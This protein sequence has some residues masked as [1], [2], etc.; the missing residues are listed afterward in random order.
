MKTIGTRIGT[1]DVVTVAAMMVLFFGITLVIGSV[2]LAIPF[3][4]L[5]MSAGIDGFLGAAF[6]LVAANR[7]NKHGL[8]LIW[9][10]VYG[11][12]LYT[13]DAADD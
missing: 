11:C 2:A 1:R 5:Y 6:Y 4:Y 8:L 10:T 9:A 13:S 3:V 12:L 7:L